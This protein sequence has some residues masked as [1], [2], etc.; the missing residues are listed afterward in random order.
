LAPKGYHIP[1][2]EEWTTLTDYLGGKQVA[3]GKMKTSSGWA[4]PNT[5]GSNSSG[6]SGLPSGTRFPDGT[7]FYIGYHGYWW[8]ST[9]FDSRKA[10]S[11][12]LNSYFGYVSSG[13]DG[14]SGFSVRCL[15]D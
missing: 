13:I 1:T 5:D 7:F 15:R 12:F 3:G 4:G 14:S 10:W 2:D 8:S 11:R 6:F 9:E